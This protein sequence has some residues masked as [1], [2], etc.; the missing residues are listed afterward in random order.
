[1]KRLLSIGLGLALG[2]LLFIAPAIAE[3]ASVT[4][5]VSFKVVIPKLEPLRLDMDQQ[6]Q[7]LAVDDARAGDVTT[8]TREVVDAYGRRH[9]R[10][11]SVNEGR[12]ELTLAAP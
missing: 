6:A 9:L 8:G 3:A 5:G 4:Q 12:V 10:Q 7:R 11:T 2:A 1:M